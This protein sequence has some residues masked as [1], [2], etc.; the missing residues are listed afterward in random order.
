MKKSKKFLAILALAATCGVATTGCSLS[1]ANS[2][3]MQ[4]L[5]GEVTTSINALMDKKFSQLEEQEAKIIL[6][7]AAANSSLQSKV[8][9]NR[10]VTTFDYL[11]YENP[12]KTESI[13]QIQTLDENGKASLYTK[14]KT[15][16]YGEYDGTL[17]EK[18]NNNALHFPG[19][20]LT[21]ESYNVC[22]EEEKCYTFYDKYSYGSYVTYEKIY[23]EGYT[24]LEIGVLGF[25]FMSILY[26]TNAELSG[27]KQ[28]D[29][30]TI[31]VSYKTETTRY[32]TFTIKNG[33][34]EKYEI[35][36]INDE[37]DGYS[38]MLVDRS[39]SEYKYNENVETPS[40]PTSTSGYT[41]PAE[42]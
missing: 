16:V 31:Y 42:E 40:F 17:Y 8:E 18:K 9:L 36:K 11:G 33:L 21:F 39:I 6:T 28:N 7:N 10:I 3:E 26:N 37:A 1:D 22:L 30:T 24:T 15:F 13:R 5:I 35:V 23:G 2:E 27:F 19:D 25:D 14:A 20:Y 41:F 32:D 4:E 29:V 34:I 12:E 38:N